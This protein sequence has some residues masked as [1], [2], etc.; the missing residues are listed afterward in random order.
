MIV[1]TFKLLL[2]AL[3]PSWRFFDEIAPSPRIE[4]CTLKTKMSDVQEWQEFRPRP[5]HMKW[6]Q[7]MRCLFYNAWWN[8]NL[9]LVALAE[10]LVQNPTKHSEKEI[11]KRIQREGEMDRPYMRFRLIFVHR[12][13]SKIQKDIIFTSDI[14]ES[15]GD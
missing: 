8:E 14:F 5:K 15:Q 3:T 11:I 2:P 7:F 10:R 4:F 1:N 9:Y 6:T 13:D 12:A